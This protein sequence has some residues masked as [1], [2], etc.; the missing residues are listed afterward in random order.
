MKTQITF[1]QYLT[2]EKMRPRH[3]AL[4]HHLV[5]STV[6]KASRGLPLRPKQAYAIYVAC[7]KKINFFALLGIEE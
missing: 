5:Q 3:F 6:W 1:K 7:D 2:K 4:R